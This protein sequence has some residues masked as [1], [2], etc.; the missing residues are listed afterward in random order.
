MPASTVAIEPLQVER[1]GVMPYDE[2]HRLQKQIHA[3]VADG[4]RSPTLLLLEHPRTITLGYSDDRRYLRHSEAV[5]A[6]R[7]IAVHVCERGGKATYHGPGQLVGY[8]IVPV[9]IRVGDY[10]RLLEA[11]LIDV[12]K[13]CGIVARGNPGYAGI[14]V[15]HADGRPAKI[16]AIGIAIRRRVAF[17]GFALNVAPDLH[18]FDLIVPCGLAGA[19]VTS[20][21]KLLGEAPAMAD[22]MDRVETVFGRHWPQMNMDEPG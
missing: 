9:R 8:P 10:L 19:A 22:V 12:L 20:L 2:A 18:D 14:W 7:G 1:M 6:Q 16:A 5:Y 15:D 17:H 3:E 13:G 21:E 11:V 4:A